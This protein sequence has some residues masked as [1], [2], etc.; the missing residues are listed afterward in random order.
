[1]DEN[2]IALIM[3]SIT[4]QKAVEILSA[5]SDF[6]KKEPDNLNRHWIMHGRSR[7]EKTKL[8]CIKLMKREFGFLL[9]DAKTR[10]LNFLEDYKSFAERI[11]QRD[12]ASYLGISP[13]TLSRIRSNQL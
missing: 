3:L 4:F 9:D 7:S 5:K 11:K 6:S 8:D 10:Y 1:L 2:E 12:V 13:E